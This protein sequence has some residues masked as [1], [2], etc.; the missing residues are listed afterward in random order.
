MRQRLGI[1]PIGLSQASRRL[2]EI[3]HLAWIDHRDREVGDAQLRHEGSLSAS[4]CLDDDHLRAE[5]LHPSDDLGN[6]GR[7]IGQMAFFT[8]GAH[9]DIQRGFGY[10]DPHGHVL[11]L[12]HTPS[13]LLPPSP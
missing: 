1:Q 2:G 3:A 7:I 9:R 8:T 12:A 13:C 4:R 5:R 6:P 10:V 11:R